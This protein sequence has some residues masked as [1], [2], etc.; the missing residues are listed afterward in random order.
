SQRSSSDKYEYARRRSRAVS[1]SLK[2]ASLDRLACPLRHWAWADEARTALD[3]E[4]A[5]GWNDDDDPMSDHPFRTSRPDLATLAESQ[6]VGPGAFVD[7]DM[8][9][10]LRNL[11]EEARL[12]P[13][14]ATTYEP[15]LQRADV[16]L[17]YDGSTGARSPSASLLTS[18]A[19]STFRRSS[20]CCSCRRD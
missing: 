7:L 10:T 18:P 2:D 8:D 9:A 16:R 3:R 19:T 20:S 11:G 14:A 15:H 6:R 1:G 13:C 5:N 17:I 12:L 4:L